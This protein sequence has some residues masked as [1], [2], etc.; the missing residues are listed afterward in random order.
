MFDSDEARCFLWI[1]LKG[2][3]FVVVKDR[4]FLAGNASS[5]VRHTEITTQDR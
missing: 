4:S 2:L 1:D 5:P 3:S